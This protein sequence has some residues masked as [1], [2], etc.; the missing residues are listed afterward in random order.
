MRIAVTGK[1]GQL[2]TALRERAKDVVILPIGRPEF[3]LRFAQEAAD[4]LKAL[5]PD[6]VISAAA[7][8]AVDKAENEPAEAGIINGDAPG[9]L[10]AAAA[11]LRIPIVHISTD[12]V[13]DGQ[14]AAPYVE[15]D[16]ACPLS[17]YG[18]TKLA[19][20]QAV[21]RATENFAILRTAWVYSPFGANFLKTMLR[22][23]QERPE[24]R[25][26]QDQ[27]GNPTSALDIADAVL[28]VVSNLVS[29]PHDGRLRGLFH[30]TANGEASWAEFASE[31]MSA[32]T[33]LGGAGAKVIPITTSEYPTLAYR[34]ANSR[35]DS[36]KLKTT[37]NISLPLW[38]DSA[39][40]VV[41]R[42]VG[43]DA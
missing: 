19:G 29:S 41:A 21:S 34:P 35:L 40:S 1:T 3:D 37:H 22:L 2:V 42:L 25:V 43:S 28:G 31:I 5:R 18:S 27:I 10:A 16:P 39:R 20:E 38:K 8:T 17:I 26:V 15:T 30:L 14:K 12:Y 6:A 11:E 24:V 23:A 33:A 9:Y 32:S 7:Y 13:F 36:T 4:V